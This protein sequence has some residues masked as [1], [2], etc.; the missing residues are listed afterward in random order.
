MYRRATKDTFLFHLINQNVRQ[1]LSK[2]LIGEF[3]EIIGTSALKRDRVDGFSA[4]Y[5]RLTIYVAQMA[6]Q[7]VAAT[8]SRH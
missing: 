8:Q 3:S 6:K 4:L 7:V 5:K 2:L 1:T